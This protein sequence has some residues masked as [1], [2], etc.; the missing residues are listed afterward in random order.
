MADIQTNPNSSVN[1]RYLSFSL[2]A[3]EYGIPLLSVKEVIAMPDFTPIPYTPPYFLGIMNL[4]GQV[5]SVMDLRKKFNIKPNPTAETAVIICDLKS[6]CIGVVVDSINSVLM[7]Q[8]DEVSGKPEIHSA[9]NTDYITGVY[10]HEKALVLFLD[11]AR[12]LNG[13]DHKAIAQAGG[14]RDARKAA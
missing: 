5:I 3:E 2:G 4:R 11:I 6:I 1:N 9:Q 14:A 12:T 10:R 8:A 13:E 7:P